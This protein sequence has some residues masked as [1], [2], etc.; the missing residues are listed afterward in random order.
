MQIRLSAFFKDDKCA[1]P[2]NVFCNPA[3]ELEGEREEKVEGFRTSS[4]TPEPIKPPAA[5]SE[6]ASQPSAAVT[7]SRVKHLVRDQA[8]TRKSSA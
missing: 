7:S 4:S 2:Q 1:S 3:F 8:R 6:L 5:A